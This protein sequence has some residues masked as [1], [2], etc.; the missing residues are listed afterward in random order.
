MRG[1]RRLRPRAG[2]GALGVVGGLFVRGFT[3][4]VPA[5]GARV[6]GQLGVEV[7]DAEYGRQGAA[8]EEVMSG[9]GGFVGGD[10][11]VGD[12]VAGGLVG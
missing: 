1:V 7:N 5:L 4:V 11:A 3:P 6:D 2:V 8:Q 10:A 12:D 9:E